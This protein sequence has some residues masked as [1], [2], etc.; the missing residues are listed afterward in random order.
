MNIIIVTW[1]YPD[2]KRSVFPF[3]KSLVEEWACQGHKCTVISP[4]SIVK[5]R[6]FHKYISYEGAR[7]N[8]VTVFRPNYFSFSNMKLF[9]VSLSSYFHKK[10]VEKTL[11]SLKEKPDVIY[12]H[13]WDS[14]YEGYRYAK[15][16]NIPLF[17]ATGES[18][19]IFERDSSEKK[20]FC[21]YLNGVICVSTKNLNESIDRLLTSKD[22]C[23]VIPNAIDNSIFKVIDKSECRKRLNFP[24]DV[25]IVSFVGWFNERKG[26]ERL[27]DAISM[28]GDGETV[29]SFFIGDGQAEPSCKNILYK[30]RLPHEKIPEY[31]NASDVFV[32]PTLQEG[33]CNAVIEAMA[34]GLPIVSSN[35][36]FNWDVLDDSNSLL[37]NPN[38]VEEIAASIMELR[39]N[40]ARRRKLAEGALR[41]ARSMTIDKR[42]KAIIDFFNEKIAGEYNYGEKNKSHKTRKHYKTL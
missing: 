22:K 39:G 6:K 15:K 35:L 36:P 7:A 20:A 9:G 3:V 40:S 4:Y 34:C 24:Q 25:F 28:I 13:F 5:N 23:I 31:L 27:S 16:N 42:A 14:A 10:A 19:I 37:I 11:Y 29:Y 17:V 21:D 38:N 33:C 18:E 30:G 2:K 12:G 8:W 26:S 41:T 1:D 32:L